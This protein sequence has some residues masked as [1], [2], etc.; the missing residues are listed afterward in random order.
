MNSNLKGIS[1]LFSIWLLAGCA[2]LIVG[3]GAGVGTYTYLKGDLKRTYQV[4]FDK[5]LGVCLSVLN[6]LNQPILKKTTDGEKTTIQ[7]ERKDG[8]PQTITVSIS[9]VDWTEVSVRTGV[10]GYWKKEVSQ[11]FHEFIA[12]RLKK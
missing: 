6:D 1:I 3:T 9:N 11:Q 5:A 2:A 10:M 8:S 7:T 4:K 12:E